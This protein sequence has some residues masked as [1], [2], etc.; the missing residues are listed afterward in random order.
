[1]NFL[2][3]QAIFEFLDQY[4]IGQNRAKKSLR[5]LLYNHYKARNPANLAARME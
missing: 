2:K 4:V 5:Q 3:P 1:V